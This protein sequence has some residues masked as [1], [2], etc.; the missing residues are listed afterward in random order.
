M[1]EVVMYKCSHCGKIGVKQTITKCE[2]KHEVEKKAAAGAKEFTDKVNA[3]R[4]TICNE[5]SSFDELFDEASR[6]SEEVSPDFKFNV[7][8]HA[9]RRVA[10]DSFVCDV[11]F[12][13]YQKPNWHAKSNN[14]PY[15]EL[16]GSDIFKKFIKVETVCG[17][18]GGS[19]YT[20]T[21]KFNFADYPLIYKSYIKAIDSAKDASLIAV[22]YESKMGELV[23]NDGIVKS[24]DS[25]IRD[26]EEQLR[27]L[28]SQVDEAK[29][30]RTNYL[31]DIQSPLYNEYCDAVDEYFD[32]VSKSPT[33]FG[34]NVKHAKKILS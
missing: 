32:D 3:F 18:G 26:L 5:A 11:S 2:K 16:W 33:N 12:S 8:R 19:S 22:E 15:K 23:K 29:K 25:A 10:H 1:E 24:F 21:C 9:V 13:V 14:H 4:E 31:E 34:I 20:Y 17:G 30:A 28:R 7:T 6:F 27:V